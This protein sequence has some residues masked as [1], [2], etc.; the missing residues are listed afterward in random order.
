MAN[1]TTRY[2]YQEPLVWFLIA[3]PLSSVLVGM[4]VLWVAVDTDDGLVV[5]DY[6]KRGLA[7]NKTLDRD[8]VARQHVLNSNLRFVHDFDQIHLVLNAEET[9]EHPPEIHLGFYHATKK[10]FD[11]EIKLTRISDKGYSGALPELIKGR[12]YLTLFHDHWRLTGTLTW[13]AESATLTF[14]PESKP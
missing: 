13:P 3:I 14:L 11:Q 8:L 6:Y 2:W 7:I 9:F 1:A 10:G 5:D 12:W 4:V